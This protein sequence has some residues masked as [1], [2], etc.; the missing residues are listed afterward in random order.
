MAVKQTIEIDAK[1]SG[2]T[3]GISKVD[4][5]LGGLVASA[6]KFKAAIGIAAAAMGAMA[7]AGKIQDTIDSFDN[8]AKSAR[9]AGA[10]ASGEAFE[11]F[12]VM[13]QAMSEA[14]IDA[15]TFDRAMLQTN[16]RIKAG[17][18]GQKSYAAVTDKLGDSLMDMNGNLKS[19]P[20]LLKSMM[21]AL[22][23]GTITTE[24]FAKVVG[25]RAGPLIQ[26][27]FASLN[28]SAEELEAT[29]S[30]VADNSNIVS[31]EAANNAEKFN[32]TVDRLKNSFGQLMTDALEP[33]MPVLVELA[34]N[35]LAKMP[36]I[37]EGVKEAFNTLQPVLELLG[38]LIT[39]VV[40]PMLKNV[41][42]ALGFI[43]EKI[44]PLVESALPL[45]KDGFQFVVDV[46]TKMW[47]IMKTIYEIALPALEAGFN[48]LKLIVETVVG[49]FQK[50]V[51]TLGALKQ[52]AIDLKN[53]TVGAFGNMKDGVVNKTTDMY[54]GVKDGAANM[55]NYL[56]GNSVFPDLRDAVI[57]SFRDMKS[58]SVSEMQN[59]TTQVNQSALTGAQ[60]FEQVFADTLGSALQTGRLDMSNFTNFFMNQIGTMGQG[61]GGF[62]GLLGKVFGGGMFGGSGGGGGGLGGLLGG[63][64]GGGGLGNL[65][66]GF[67][68]DGGKLGA[69]K[70]GIAGESG[71][72]IIHGPASVTPMEQMGGNSAQVNITIQAVDTQ[73]GTEF[74]LKNKRQIEG[75]I[76]N[77]FNKRG[78]QGIY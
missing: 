61:A 65:F 52:K 44:A 28:T 66:G 56:V 36:D 27:Q 55:Y 21:N 26:E 6:G 5:G 35:I 33:L 32:D 51:D 57:A 40:W 19:G 70:F 22:N 75:I 39:E 74:L 2:A 68:A 23:E 17:L 14:G 3:A 50:A 25:G 16:S 24:E 18:E 42:E 58:G 71:A 20:E 1:V 46:A 41:F 30:D 62:G 8:L 63:L 78:R 11:G 73:S 69:G 10:A 13:K 76:Q 34:E 47:D 37:I 45:L 31:L 59:M 4:K 54:N 60:S 29:L 12:Q 48:G 15:A 77:A 38:T 64:F 67:F 7:V 49:I 53:A 9:A 43:A 72:E